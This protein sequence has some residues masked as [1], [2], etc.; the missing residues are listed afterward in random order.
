MGYL[1]HSAG[2][3]GSGVSRGEKNL[4][5]SVLR[6]HSL[7]LSSA[8]KMSSHPPCADLPYSSRKKHQRN[9]RQSNLGYHSGSVPRFTDGVPKIPSKIWRKEDS[10]YQ[11]LLLSS[12]T[13]KFIVT[14]SRSLCF[15]DSKYSSNPLFA[16]LI[17]S[18]FKL[19]RNSLDLLCWH[20][21]HGCPRLQKQA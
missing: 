1:P 12:N 3:G 15:R 2:R 9:P 20:Y 7:W 11:W 8:G 17:F 13:L 16:L 18:S 19:Q 4:C 6:D 5:P 21:I 10:Q 14:L